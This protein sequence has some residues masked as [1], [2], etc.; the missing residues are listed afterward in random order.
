M[1]AVKFL[2]N[3]SIDNTVLLVEV[4]RLYYDHHFSQQQIAQKLGISRPG[5][6]RILSQAREQGIVRIEVFDPSENGTQMET[7]LQRKF[8]L[9]KVIIV[10]DE[11]VE[12]SVIKQRLGMAAAKYLDM[13]IG[14]GLTLGVS[15]GSTMQEVVKHLQPKRVKN[16]TVVQLVGGF[17]KAEYDPHASEITKKIGENYQAILFLLPLP[18]IVDRADVKQ[19]ILSDKNISKALELARRAE[20]ALFSVGSFDTDSVL[21]KAEY[22]ETKEVEFLLKRRAVGDICSRIIADTGEICWPELDARTI[23]IELTDLHKKPFAI[24][25]AGGQKKLKAIHAGL[26]GKYFNVLITDEGIANKLMGF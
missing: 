8:R 23:G 18:A 17:T 14:D 19:A 20:M 11:G 4:A 1:I 15:W 2:M 24:A 5:V 13:M 3:S 25:V 26:L 10:P 6:S 16:M 21:V 7:D 22:I 9:K 12:P